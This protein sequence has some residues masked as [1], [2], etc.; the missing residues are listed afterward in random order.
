[1]SPLLPVVWTTL[2]IVIL[3]AAIR[4][5][6]HPGA[7]R[8]G[9]IAV[10]TLYLAAGAAVNAALLLVGEDYHAFAD[11]AYLPFVRDTWRTLVVPNHV[12]FISV[13]IVYEAAVGLLVLCGGRRAEL[14][15]LGA[16]GFHLALLSF[17]W[18]IYLW[19]VPMLV[20]LSLLLR[21]QHRSVNRGQRPSPTLTAPT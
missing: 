12:L 11:E 16:I 9:R 4:A 15:L 18:G 2:G 21:A 5:N 14:G 17:G 10:A 13:L 6:R 19:C 20:A 7:L 1:M 8:T 3:V